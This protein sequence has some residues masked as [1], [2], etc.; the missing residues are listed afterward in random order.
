MKNV[1]GFT[2]ELCCSDTR[3]SLSQRGQKVTADPPP[4]SFLLPPPPLSGKEK[5]PLY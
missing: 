2:V 4:S 3:M 5:S 1:Q